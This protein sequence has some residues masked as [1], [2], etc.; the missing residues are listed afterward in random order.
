MLKKRL[1]YL[2]ILL[3]SLLVI[4]IFFLKKETRPETGEAF[5]LIPIDAALVIQINNYEALLKKFYYQSGIWNELRNASSFNS[6][7]DQI[8]F[9]DSI[10]HNIPEMKRLLTSTTSY[11]SFHYTGRD[12]INFLHIFEIP[13]GLTSRKINSLIEEFVIRQGTISER[14][15]DGKK[16]YEIRLLDA[17]KTKGVGY[18]Y[19]K[20]FFVISFSSLLLEDVIRQAESDITILN[21]KG[22]NKALL[23]AGKNV[24]ANVFISFRNLPKCFS[25]AMNNEYKAEVRAYTSFAEWG[26]LDVNLLKDVFLLNGFIL[27]SDS[28]SYTASIFHKQNPQKI[29]VDEV[30]PSSIASFLVMA[31]S[32]GDQYFEDYHKYL[33]AIGKY[34]QYSRSLDVLKNTYE[35]DFLQEFIQI[36][37][38]EI[39]IAFDAAVTDG[40]SKPNSYLLLKVKSQ[41]LAE[42]RFSS[43]IRRMNLKES[44]PSANDLR[45]YKIDNEL[46]YKIYH[47]PIRKITGKIF[48]DIFANIDNHYFAF[49]SN[50]VVFSNSPEALGKLLHDIVLNKTIVTNSAYKDFKSNI[51]PKSNLYFYTNIGKANMAFTRYLSERLLSSWNQN[52]Q[53]FQKIQVFGFQMYSS[54]DMLYTN[55]I[56]KHFTDFKDQPH[57]VW[58]SRLDTTIDIKPVFVLNHITN[59]NEVFVQDK[60]N[61]I[62]LINQAG[63]ILWKISIAEKI[64]SEIYQIDY[65]KNRKLQLLFS[66]RN[67]IHLL[68]RNGNYVEKY[69]VKLRSPATN[70]L[71]VFDYEKNR[72]YRLFIA[73]EDRR[74]YAY[75]VDGSLVKGWNFNETESN[76]TQPVNH[77][78]VGT[79]DYLVFGDRLKTYILDRRGYARVNVTEYFPRSVQ[80]NYLIDYQRNETDARLVVTDTTGLIH[81]ISFNGNHTTIDMGRFTGNHFFDCK[82]MDGDNKVEY[83]FLDN[84]KLIIFKENKTLLY[85]FTFNNIIYFRPM[86]YNFGLRDKKLGIVSDKENLIYLINN[87]GQPYKGFPLRGNSPFSIGYLNK[88]STTF[89]LIVG[90][91]DNFL[92]NYTVQ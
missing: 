33:K 57:T 74:V 3:F 27:T 77:F 25:A 65:F 9:L 1:L 35:I 43:I 23:T 36:W 20:N 82:D 80:N 6:L 13:K 48:G 87:D 8:R 52:I 7:N 62:Y 16:L 37:D 66:T 59:Q 70:G 14:N 60:N 86:Y 40:T 78:R 18:C 88:N 72:D 92:Y 5:R 12:K 84:N 58:E 63:R 29:T 15:Y 45:I 75:N 76:V 44:G 11:L 28:G 49:V 73:C 42:D 47:L 69:P 64:T 54:N 81:C 89:N 32:N 61:S 26:E 41:S 85:E 53:A 68:D 38:N 67:Y 22:F 4:S 30:L 56:L 51:S 17:N 21:Q 91:N 83:I 2:I 79:K 90:N 24:D 31:V 55:L 34:N 71:A 39:T 10:M 46:S 50:Y 19:V